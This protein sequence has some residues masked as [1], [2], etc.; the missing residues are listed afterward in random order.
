MASS[1]KLPLRRAA[2]TVDQMTDVLRRLGDLSA[3]LGGVRDDGGIVLRNFSEAP[4]CTTL[5]PPT[6]VRTAVDEGRLEMA[7]RAVEELNRCIDVGDEQQYSPQ[8]AACMIKGTFE[9][10]PI[11]TEQVKSLPPDPVEPPLTGGT[12]PRLGPEQIKLLIAGLRREL[13]DLA[14]YIDRIDDDQTLGRVVWIYDYA[15]HT[16]ADPGDRM[17]LE[18][19]T[20][21][22]LFGQM[23][24]TIKLLNA[25]LGAR[26][27]RWDKTPR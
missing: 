3:Y 14:R 8:M 21:K 18:G 12:L 22:A 26:G 7:L 15:A 4:A 6:S 17:P 11:M 27:F 25:G 19:T 9:P 20:D 5:P 1:T 24:D 23:Q 2:T 13:A 10:D 16:K